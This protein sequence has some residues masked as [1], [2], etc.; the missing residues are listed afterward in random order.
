ME[1][2][3][4][5]R[6]RLLFQ[7]ALEREPS[8]RAEFLAEACE[9][10]EALRSEVSSLL[11]AHEK[12]ASFL[13]TAVPE[14]SRQPA[15]PLSPG[16]RLG[17]YEI[18]GLIGAG[19]MGEVYRA[20]D[21]KLGRDV[22]IKTLPG[23][24]ARDGDHLARFR[25]EARALASLN[26]PSVAA[27]HGLEESGGVHFLVLELVAGETLAERLEGGP[28]QVREALSIAHQIAE[29]LEAAHER[30]VVHRD[31][32]P[33]NVKI[34]P[35]GKVKVLDFGL[36][37][38]SP[39]PARDLDSQVS[40]A[41]AEIT[42]EGT[43]LGTAAYM[44]PEQ[45]RG[46]PVDKRTDIWSFG[47]LTYEMLT[48]RRAFAGETV[49][50]AI[51]AILTAEPDWG[52]LPEATPPGLRN[53][54]RRCL[55]KDAQQRLRDIGDARLELAEAL[56][57]RAE[58]AGAAARRTRRQVLAATGALAIGLALLLALWHPGRLP[59]QPPPARE[60]TQRQIT[61]NTTD[62]PVFIA[63]VSPDGRYL[64]YTDFGG[65]HLRLIETAETRVLPVPDQFCFR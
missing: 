47:C 7:Q 57:P 58:S 17:P 25:R 60:L 29:G 16:T 36:A 40:T 12:A 28:L 27:I 38:V 15:I 22:A 41:A 21:S 63:A 56:S 24:F 62:D 18:R 51:A 33:A 6:V 45:A 35:Q 9:A 59:R 49:T 64:A 30:G 55:E 32:K 53:L 31:L 20:F 4:W 19:G 1:A 26:H 5:Q 3:R 65:L 8:R 34:T 48:G 13:A 10:D 39:S 37:K 50:D 44:S 14:E 43:I 23:A 54:L 2:E 46:K 42:R 61:G 11:A 52:R